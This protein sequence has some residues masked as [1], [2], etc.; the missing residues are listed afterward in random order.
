MNRYINNIHD[1]V[2]IYIDA[3]NYIKLL[4]YEISASSIIKYIII[5]W[6]G[7]V[8]INNNPMP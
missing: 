5:G 7:G 2:N 1:G 3:F 4:A 8:E 6:D